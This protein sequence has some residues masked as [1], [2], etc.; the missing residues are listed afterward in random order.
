[1]Y[2]GKKHAFYIRAK[3][4]YI[5]GRWELIRSVGRKYLSE[6]AQ[7]KLEWIIFYHTVGKESATNTAKH[8]SITR[9]TFHKWLRRFV[10]EDPTTLEEVSRKPT[11]T[12]HKELSFIQ[13]ER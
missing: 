6:K 7:L 4:I 9:K 8:F 11:N 5:P 2:T 12:R 1:M 3:K 10:E 13:E